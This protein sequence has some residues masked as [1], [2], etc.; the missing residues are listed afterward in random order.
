MM[1]NLPNSYL[2]KF[3]SSIKQLFFKIGS[4]T[5]DNIESMNHVELGCLGS[6]IGIKI[7]NKNIFISEIMNALE[8]METVPH[9]VKEYYPDITDKEWQ[10]SA[11]LTTLILVLFE[12]SLKKQILK[13][14]E[15]LKAA[16]SKNKIEMW[17]K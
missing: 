10:A 15:M 2:K 16:F 12:K 17:N 11:R 13:D 4:E 1:N 5:E 8:D 7:K 3:D 6:D 9:E 14:L